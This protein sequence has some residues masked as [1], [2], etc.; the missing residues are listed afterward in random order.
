MRSFVKLLKFLK[1]HCSFHAEE[2]NTE[3]EDII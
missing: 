3:T 2:I 1:I